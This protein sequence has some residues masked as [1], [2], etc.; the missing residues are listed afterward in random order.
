MSVNPKVLGDAIEGVVAINKEKVDGVAVNGLMHPPYNVR[1][2]GATLNLTNVEIVP[3]QGA[4]PPSV[5]DDRV[6]RDSELHGRESVAKHEMSSPGLSANLDDRPWLPGSHKVQKV[7][8][9][10]VDLTWT[11]RE[12]LSGNRHH[13]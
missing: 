5:A 6:D 10:C 1:V 9:F 2:A 7:D 4:Q 8:D 3:L 12:E 11:A 13:V